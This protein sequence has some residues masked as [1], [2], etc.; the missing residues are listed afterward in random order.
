M[1]ALSKNILRL[2]MAFVLSLSFVLPANA[3]FLMSDEV[4]CP[5]CVSELD[6]ADAVMGC[7]SESDEDAPAPRT[8]CQEGDCQCPDCPFCPPHVAPLIGV[9][10]QLMPATSVRGHSLFSPNMGLEF[11]MLNEAPPLPPPRVS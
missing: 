6:E 7:C 3:V 11:E 9:F 8:P 1:A 2:T 5:T 4:A 10:T